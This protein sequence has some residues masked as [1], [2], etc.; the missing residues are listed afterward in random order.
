MLSVKLVVEKHQLISAAFNHDEMQQI[1]SKR[2]QD[3]CIVET[4]GLPKLKGIANSE[5]IDRFKVM[6]IYRQ[7]QVT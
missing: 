5:L 6:R 4:L 7:E 3:D 1:R 2:V